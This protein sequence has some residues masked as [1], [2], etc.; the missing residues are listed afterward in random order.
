M[1]PGQTKGAERAIVRRLTQEG[2][3]LAQGGLG[4]QMTLNL[5]GRES[6]WSGPGQDPGG[7]RPCHSWALTA[8]SSSQQL[9]LQIIDDLQ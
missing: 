4:A 7:H 2:S 3:V 6:A 8:S 5:D 1:E 9:L